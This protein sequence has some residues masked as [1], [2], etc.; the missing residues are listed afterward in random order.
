VIGRATMRRD[1][2]GMT[3]AAKYAEFAAREA[4]GVSPAYER[5]SLAVSRDDEVLALL[6]TLPPGKRQPNLLFGVVRFLGGPVE[7]PAA[8]HGLHG[9]ELAGDRGGDAHQGHADE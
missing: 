6:G 3:T 7:D 4:P 8:F 5:L 1:H 9:G 2:W